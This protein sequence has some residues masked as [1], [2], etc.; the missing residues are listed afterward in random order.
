MMIRL[1]LSSFQL[2]T[3]DSQDC[4]VQ[5]FGL[6]KSEVVRRERSSKLK[7][8]GSMDKNEK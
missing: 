8:L 1:G 4:S 7:R 2:D 5:A 3:I 6:L